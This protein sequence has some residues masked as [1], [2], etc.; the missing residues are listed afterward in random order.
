MEKKIAAFQPYLFP[1][2][3]YYQLIHAVDE[4]VFLDNVNYIKRGFSNRNY[5]IQNGKPK[6]FTIPV[7]NASQNRKF[8]DIELVDGWATELWNQTRFDISPWV[9]S[10]NVRMLTT[11]STSFAK[12]LWEHLDLPV[13]F[14][15]SRSLG[16]EETGQMRII[17]TVKKLGGNVYINPERPDLYDKELFADHGIELR[18]IKPQFAEYPQGTDVFH[19]KMSILDLLKNCS[20]SELIKQ[21]KN[22]T[23]ERA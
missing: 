5:T 9:A 14:R 4:F 7:K 6:R 17:E 12:R 2:I 18:W 21:L 13:N 19:P 20:K 1:Y 8:E 22:Y 10:V 23:I 11:V 16:I 3:G 15:Y